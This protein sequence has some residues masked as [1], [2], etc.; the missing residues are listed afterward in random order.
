MGMVTFSNSV[1]AGQAASV[2]GRY[3]ALAVL[4][5]RPL[6]I[7]QRQ[8]L[9]PLALP[10]DGQAAIFL[11][12]R[13]YAIHQGVHGRCWSHMLFASTASTSTSQHGNREAPVSEKSVAPS[14]QSIRR[15]FGEQIPG[16]D[17]PDFS[18]CYIKELMDL[19]LRIYRIKTSKTEELCCLSCKEAR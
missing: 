5:A 15:T 8:T 2:F 7:S 17:N 14:G 18:K 12:Q 19:L 13:T 11:T 10:Q 3:R 4:L 1:R 16:T 9:Q 6:A